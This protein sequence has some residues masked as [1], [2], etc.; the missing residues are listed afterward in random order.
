M[1]RYLIFR[2]DR[3]GDFLLT[4]ILIKNIRRNDKDSHIS[5]ICS[6]KNYDYIRSFD[7]VDKTYLFQND[8]KNKFRLIKELRKFVFKYS[9]IH[10]GKKRSFFIN[11]FLKNIK[12]LNVD[13]NDIKIS[14][15][16]KIKKII[17]IMNFYYKD[18]DL[19]TLEN[20]DQNFKHLNRSNYIILHYDEKWSNKTYIKSYKNIEPSEAQLFNFLLALRLKFNLHVVVTTGTKP[21]ILL[22]TLFTKVVDKKIEFIEN[23]NFLELEYL[24]SKSKLLISCHGAISHIAAAHKIK[25][26][27]II[28]INIKNP[29]TNWTEH[30]RNYFFLYRE[31]FINLSNKILK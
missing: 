23:L 5:V 3:I 18:I 2:T 30:F 27:D 21:P 9:I 1:N 11:L 13:N 16:N 15:I 7:L 10:D 28:D 25:Q 26:I 17:K 20:R 8:Y 29:Y 19:N 14:H 24:V 6:K 22:N 12:T 4:L 31:D